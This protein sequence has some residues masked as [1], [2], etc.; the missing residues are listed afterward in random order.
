MLSRALFPFSYIIIK[1]TSIIRILKSTPIATIKSHL[2][3][4][5]AM[6]P[7]IT[8]LIINTLYL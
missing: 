2:S 6:V 7:R 4:I 5:K 1:L 3:I 8:I